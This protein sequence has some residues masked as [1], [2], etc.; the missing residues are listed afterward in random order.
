MMKFQRHECVLIVQLQRLRS[1][2]R[3]LAR[4]LGALFCRHGN[5]WVLVKGVHA[6]FGLLFLQRV[7]SHGLL[8]TV[9]FHH[10]R[11]ACGATLL[12]PRYWS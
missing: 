5:V 7:P 11:E 10:G 4:P 8:L 2:G 9:L 1:F 3:Y 6:V 12:L